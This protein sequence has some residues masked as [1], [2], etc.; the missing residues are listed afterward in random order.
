MLVLSKRVGRAVLPRPVRR[1]INA[2]RY[3]SDQMWSIC[4]ST[5]MARRLEAGVLHSRST[6][7]FV[8]VPGHSFSPLVRTSL[9]EPW[10]DWEQRETIG[11]FKGSAFIEPT[12]GWIICGPRHLVGSCLIDASSARK[13]SFRRYLQTRLW[14]KREI[15]EEPRLIHL[16]DWGEGN[17]WHFLND[18]IGGR[19]RL[20]D[21]AGV[22]ADVPLLIGRR[23]FSQPFV[24]E[25]LRSSQIERRRLLVQGDEMFHCREII[26]FETPRHSVESTDFVL[27]CLGAR[28]G[29]DRGNKRLFLSRGRGARR[30]IENLPEIEEVCRRRGF[31]VVETEHMSLAEQIELF[32]QVRY[33]VAIHGAGLANI[34]F[35]RGARLDLLEIFPTTAYLSR[36]GRVYPPPAHYFWLAHACGFGYEAIF[37][38]ARGQGDFES[39]FPVDATA[40]DAKIKA[41]LT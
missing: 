6:R 3:D 34:M 21:E 28:G 37:G 24:Q 10:R 35:R 4:A 27:G 19:L 29:E 38:T 17:Y 36:S 13:P 16:R 25:V 39:G 9:L 22:S 31:E 23:A 1:L 2:Y 41:M 15:K 11:V 30:T 14:A 33:L 32:S 5:R 8:G 18:I 40:L 12:G 7:P 20:A 26:H